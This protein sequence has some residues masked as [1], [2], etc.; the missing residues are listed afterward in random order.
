MVDITEI[1]IHGH[2]GRSQSKIAASLGLDRKTVK[3]YVDPAIAAGLELGGPPRPPVEWAELVHQMVSA[4]RR[5]AG[6]GDPGRWP[7]QPELGQAAAPV[8]ETGRAVSR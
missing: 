6:A 7:C 8:R 1:L 2:A 4:D 3:K 5:H